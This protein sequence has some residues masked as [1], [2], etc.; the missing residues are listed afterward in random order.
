MLSCSL[1]NVFLF[2]NTFF[3]I[4]TYA[5]LW[6][7]NLSFGWLPGACGPGYRSRY[8]DSLRPGRS[9]DR[10][11][12][13]GEIFRTHPDLS[14]GLPSLLYNWYR[15][16][17]EDKAAGA[18]RWPTTPS[19]AEV[20]ER[21]ELSLYS[22]Y[23]PSWPVLRWTLPLPLPRVW[24]L[25]ADVSEHCSSVNK[26]NIWFTWP[27]KM[28]QIVPRR[29]HIKFRRRGITKKKQYNKYCFILQNHVVEG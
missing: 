21:A 1:I 17:P 3:Y 26:K 23:G 7:C 6:C 10:I 9:G 8:S 18:W 19:S 24:I 16:F 25:C 12:V 13:G 4:Q 20:K 27:R 11:L 14:W 22:T 5:V 28:E 2:S 29:R 15:V